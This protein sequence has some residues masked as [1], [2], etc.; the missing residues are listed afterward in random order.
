[1][2]PF[3]TVTAA[4]APSLTP[5]E[6]IGDIWVK[7]DDL[8]TFGGVCGGKVRT[9]VALASGATGGLVTAGS[10]SSPQVNIVAHVAAAMGL[11]ACVH[12]PA[13][14]L[15]PEVEAAVAAG[16][17]LVQHTAG[18]N[19][20]IIARAR[21][22]AKVR[23]WCLIPFGMECAAAIENTAAQVANVPAGVKRIVVPVGSGMSLIGILHGL[24]NAGRL[25]PI[26]GV[27]VGADPAARLTRTA[28]WWQCGAPFEIFKAPVPYSRSVSRSL[29]AITLDPIYEA[30]CVDYL[31]A[32]D[33]FWI[34]GIR[35]TA[36]AQ[37]V[38]AA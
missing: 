6:K 15:S 34:V 30:K 32:G 19:N 5:V 2:L 7:R 31:R 29:G 23:G 1:M 33:L 14:K 20:V 37:G 36:L 10:R 27:V 13:G 25:V 12:T 38:A 17:A 8:Y 11:P 16:A 18:Y 24:R 26:L 35:Q 22:C 28:A 21:D 3:E 9:C 4:P